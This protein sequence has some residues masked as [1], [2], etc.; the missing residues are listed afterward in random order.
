METMM[1]PSNGFLS[2]L[3]ADDYELIR[4]HLRTADLP[5]E[6]VL[7]ETGETLRRAYF[8]HRGVISL[9]VELAKGEHVQVAMI[10]RDSLLG[11]LAIVGDACALNTAIVLVPGVASV[12]DLDRLRMAADQ[13]STL[14]AQLSRHGLAVYAQVQQTAGCNAAHPVESRLS[15]CL[16]HTHD[17]SGESRL[18]LTQETMA[19]MI[20][21]RRNSVS[22]VANSLQ[23]ANF[24]HYSRGHIQIT[25]LDGLRQ[26]ACECYAA[27][28]GQYDRLLG[29]H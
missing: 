8:P 22:L 19:Q 15:R 13:S 24:I 10:G 7:V 27:V 2:A 20:G 1:R 6:A 11:T 17:L 23:Q 21:A 18:L 28:K 4:P 5:H 9:V 3:S 29:P 25:N 16:L 14:R 26:T 12:V